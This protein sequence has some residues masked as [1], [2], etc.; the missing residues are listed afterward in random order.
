MPQTLR[1]NSL[2]HTLRLL[3]TSVFTRTVR[4]GFF[5]LVLLAFLV[6]IL[7]P[8]V[9]LNVLANQRTGNWILKQAVGE[10][11]NQDAC[12]V[13][14]DESRTTVTGPGLSLVGR[15]TYYNISIKRKSPLVMLNGKTLEYSFVNLPE[16][17]V[18]YD[19][20]RL[21]AL[22][23]S[24]VEVPQQALFHFNVQDG[25]WLDADLFKSGSGG[26]SEIPALPQFIVRDAKVRVRAN[27]V[28][29]APEE[30]PSSSE[31]IKPEWYDFVLSDL[32]LLPSPANAEIYLLDGRAAG[33]PFGTFSVAGSVARDGSRTEVLFAQ[34]GLRLDDALVNSL[35]IE[36]RRIYDQF[37]IKGIADIYC[38]LVIPQGRPLEFNAD[39]NIKQG[40]LCFVGFPLA[41]T[42]ATARL[43]V[44][45]NTVK[46]ESILGWRD[47]AKVFVSGQVSQIGQVGET[48]QIS[49]D[50]RDLLI[51]EKFRVGLL[52]ARLQPGNENPATGL[53]YLVDQW[54][55]ELIPGRLSW[56]T[57]EDWVRRQGYPEWP[58]Q[59][60]TAG[61]VVY[62]NL[63]EVLPFVARSFMPTG[64]CNFKFET[65]EVWKGGQESIKLPDG[66]MTTKRITDREQKWF[67]YVRD[68][69]ACYLG[70]PELGEGG[71]PIPIFRG[72]GVVEGTVKTG[73]SSKFLV[74]GYLQDELLRIP[75]AEERGMR[76]SQYLT[77]ERA[78]PGQRIML[79][80]TY[81]DPQEL[82]D[83]DL[84]LN[85]TS[86]GIDIDDEFKSALPEG[87]RKV[88]DLFQPK[89]RADV[90]SAEVRIIPA[91]DWVNYQFLIKAK[92]IVAR[93]QFEGASRPVELT[94]VEGNLAIN[95]L[96]GVVQ[97]SGLR[98]R[99]AGSQ[100]Y[101]DV[102]HKQGE[103]KPS[104]TFSAGADDFAIVPVLIDMLPP[105]VA[106]VF[107]DFEP[108]GNF[109]LNLAGKRD[110]PG[111]ANIVDS[112]VVFR[113]GSVRYVKFPYLLSALS[114]R[115][116]VRV[117]DDQVEVTLQDFGGAGSTKESSVRIGGHL[118]VPLEPQ[119]ADSETKPEPKPLRYDLQINAS[120]V[121]VDGTLLDALTPLFQPDGNQAK[122]ALVKFIEELNIKGSIGVRGRIF[123]NEL[124]ENL[125]SIELSLE[126]CSMNYL[127]FP[128]PVGDLTGSILVDGS[129][130]SF[131][132]LHGRTEG[133]GSVTLT[134]AGYSDADGWHVTLNAREVP[135]SHTLRNALP[136][137]L[138]KRFDAAKPT[139]T[140]D[141]DVALQGRNDAFVFQCAVDLRDTTLD[142]GLHFEKVNA[143]L[144]LEGLIENDTRR[145][146][147]NLRVDS[148]L[149]KDAEF[150]DVTSEVQ[151][152]GDRL[153]LPNMRGQFYGG[154]IEGAISVND[155]EYEGAVRVRGADLG[156]LG[157]TA[158]PKAGELQGAIDGE[159]A[160][161]SKP[162]V[163]GQ[164][165]RG[166]VDVAAF[167]ATSK[168]EKRNTAKLAE[169]P[170]FSQMFATTKNPQNF[171]EGH[172]FFWLGQ[173]RVTIREMDFVS[174]AARVETFGGDEENYIVYA[175][176]E[177]RMKLFFTIAPRA[178]LAIPG[179]QQVFDLLKQ[180]LFP[181]YV[182]GTLN[183][184]KVE[185]FSLAQNDLDKQ[186]DVFPRP[187]REN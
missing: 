104:Y 156:A 66:R 109:L 75:E 27:A 145:A 96:T 97:V 114:G 1:R 79:R 175:T 7:A 132:N 36:V 54:R 159:I 122:P 150:N 28:L 64:F 84:I 71:F 35:S 184:P 149:W 32:S 60:L 10:L 61:G 186:R 141:A 50:I 121:N 160:F 110:V 31:G 88:V 46:I 39:I 103:L 162:D 168:D 78:K 47:S 48:L 166:R 138:I 148:L 182:T 185:A 57:D 38:R 119:V 100:V 174:D 113:G 55:P 53:P 68:A 3:T 58:G 72:Y 95:S 173:D 142:V 2:F 146:N 82:G 177:M 101:M 33:M 98:G 180:I 127:K 133:Q 179:I 155:S 172:L 153:T 52:E 65:R 128:Y 163:N 69:S 45:N 73:T 129:N 29:R 123:S 170:L 105:D 22:P 107:A 41:V 134:E 151:L 83:P 115:V 12:D 85:I 5:R 140:F 144:D 90:E 14:W 165:G 135:F 74:R 131:R 80:A 42:P 106:K 116:F 13:T 108:T 63:D 87:I 37:Q 157:K 118:L 117:R 51:D 158:F 26:E 25:R 139:G 19:L 15:V 89:G 6:F 62:P 23:L 176:G 21:P 11:F 126:G 24:S 187:P 4:R 77:A 94:D 8:M 161:Y 137:A 34:L 40:R 67:V 9:A 99:I 154:S 102:T 147:G 91:R 178:P 181:L 44:H 112:E 167:D 143:R 59:P 16:L 49:V 92:S 86:D 56:E 111:E 17:T 164:I 18:S 70:L 93:Y 152:F 183:S 169:V 125:W 136:A 30:L 81:T 130:I 20:K 76:P 120:R 43:H 171:D 124:G